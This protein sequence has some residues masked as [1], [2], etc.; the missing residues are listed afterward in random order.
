MIRARTVRC[1]PC[2]QSLQDGQHE[3]CRL[4]GAG[5]GQAQH[6]APFEHDG[7]GLLLDGG[8]RGKAG[9]FDAGV[10]ARIERKLFKVH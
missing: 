7:N 5:L 9:R 10:D 2:G 1:G 3:G 4:A 6:V 8:G